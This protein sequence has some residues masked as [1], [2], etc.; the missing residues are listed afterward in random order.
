MKIVRSIWFDFKSFI[1]IIT[2]IR[3][4]AAAA[5]ISIIYNMH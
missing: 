1:I 4:A 3:S 5:T 2:T